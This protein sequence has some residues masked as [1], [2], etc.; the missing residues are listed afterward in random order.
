VQH[1]A[2][3]SV[4]AG[5]LWGHLLHQLH[6]ARARDDALGGRAAD[7]VTVLHRGLSA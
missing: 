5:R 1:G 7:D 2:A 3:I 4:D 6:R